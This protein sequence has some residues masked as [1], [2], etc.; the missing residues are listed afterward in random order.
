MSSNHFV[1]AQ[2][3]GLDH[4]LGMR[5]A[6]KV[7]ELPSPGTGPN[8]NQTTKVVTCGCGKR[9]YEAPASIRSRMSAALFGE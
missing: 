1:E 9:R 7:L 2:E 4:L 6:A 8:A 5:R 3:D